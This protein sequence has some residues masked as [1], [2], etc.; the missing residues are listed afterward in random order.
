MDYNNLNHYAK[1]RM[2]TLR[3]ENTSV[4]RWSH[5]ASNLYV[6]QLM[7]ARLQAFFKQEKGRGQSKVQRGRV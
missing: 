6:K 7:L 2:A 5:F 3:G 1:E 4:E